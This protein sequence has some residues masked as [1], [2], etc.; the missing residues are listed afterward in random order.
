MRPRPVASL[1]GVVGQASDPFAVVWDH[2]FV[3]SIA[4]IV[5]GGGHSDVSLGVP[6]D[7]ARACHYADTRS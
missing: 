4:E 6:N 5:G 2:R 1:P 7:G 3:L